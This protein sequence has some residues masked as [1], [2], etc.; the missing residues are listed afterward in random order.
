[1]PSSVRIC[2][3]YVKIW[4]IEWNVIVPSVPDDYVSL[5]LRLAQDLLIVNT[6]INYCLLY[7]SD[8]AD[9]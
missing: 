9:E 6:C 2:Y 5:F 3:N 4:F 8:A 1:M 7:T